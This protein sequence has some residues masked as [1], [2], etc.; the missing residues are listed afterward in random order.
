MLSWVPWLHMMERRLGR[1]SSHGRKSGHYWPT[2]RRMV[3]GK[4][5]LPCGT[6]SRTCTR[7]PHR[8]LT[9]GSQRSHLL[10]LEED[11]TSAVANA[12]RLGVGLGTVCTDVVESLS[13]ILKRAYNDHTARRGGGGGQ[14]PGATALQQEG[15]GGLARL[16]V[17]VF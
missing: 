3:S 13:A 4:P 14:M 17:V 10:D 6:S 1:C 16:G 15:G 5:W 7:K 2:P 11:V 9:Y 12:A 8:A